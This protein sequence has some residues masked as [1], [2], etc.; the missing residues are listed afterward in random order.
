M[1]GDEPSRN[2]A[3]RM[4]PV[5]IL[6]VVPTYEEAE[7]VPLLLER[8]RDVRDGLDLHL[9]VVDDS[10]PDGTAEVVRDAQLTHPWLHL[11]RRP[12]RQGLGSAYRDGFRW[13]L[14]NGYE[15]IGE[16]DA[17]LSHDPSALPALAA[18]LDRGAD[19]ALGS[20]YVAG[21][22]SKGWPLRRR[23]LSRGA[24]LFARTLLELDVRDVTSGYRLFSSRAIRLLLETGTYCDGYGFQVEGVHIL[25]RAGYTIEEVPITFRDRTFGTSKMSLATASEAARRCFALARS[26]GPAVSER[27]SV[28]APGIPAEQGEGR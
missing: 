11:L 27:P 22:G 17:D 18:C 2:K 5:P 9:L 6:M 10:S 1:A 4:S 19:L 24:N 15:R 26:G 20:R 12:G 23:L 7:N 8:L 28:I 3:V 13:G 14:D 21:G 16:M 25:H